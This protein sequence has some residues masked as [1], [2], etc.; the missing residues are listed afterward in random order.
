MEE[1]SSIFTSNNIKQVLKS[2][3]ISDINIDELAI[4]DIEYYFIHLRARSV[5]EEVELKY[6][7]QN[8]V[9]KTEEV[10]IEGEKEIITKQEKCNNLMEIRYNLLDI[11]ISENFSDGIIQLTP[12]IGIKLKYPDYTISEE[13]K[14]N[15]NVAEATINFIVSCI[16]YVFDETN[17]FQAKD[18]KQEELKEFIEALTVDQ[19]NKIEDF[20][21]KIPKLSKTLDVKC[22]KCGFAHKIVVEGLD[23]FFG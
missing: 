4:I 12:K 1:E 21:K 11:K 19:F 13:F 10:T 2:C 14:N 16:E 23:N 8:L 5:G 20:F 6:R 9:E 17:M 7:C 3:S 15:K 22:K 18:H